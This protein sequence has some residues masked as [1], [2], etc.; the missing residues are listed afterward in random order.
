MDI[1]I[2]WVY[3]AWKAHRNGSGLENIHT[4]RNA[5]YRCAKT[6]DNDVC[7]TLTS[8]NVRIGSSSSMAIIFSLLACRCVTNIPC[9][10]FQLRAVA[11]QEEEPF[12]FMLTHFCW[13]SCII[14][15]L[16]RFPHI[17]S[18]HSEQPIGDGSCCYHKVPNYVLPLIGTWFPLDFN[19]ACKHAN[20]L[21]G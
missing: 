3:Y 14:L 10:E 13:C 4:T 2:G 9:Q 11:I 6:N 18:K 5:R 19:C 16:F 7:Q 1:R 17:P 20:L 21:V 12:P 8:M 15:F